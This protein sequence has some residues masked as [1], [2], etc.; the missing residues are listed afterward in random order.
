MKF[1]LAGNNESKLREMNSI[2]TSIG[3][4]VVSQRA[5]GFDIHTEETGSTFEENAF[6][7]ANELMKASNMP[8][9]ADDSGLVV[10]ALDGDP[11][12]YSARYGG[13]SCKSDADRVNLLLKNMENKEQRSAKFVSCVVCIFPDGR[14]IT[15]RGEVMGEIAKQPSGNGGFGYD[16]VFYLPEYEATM[17]EITQEKKNMVSHRGRAL[18]KLRIELENMEYVNN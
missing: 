6:L 7:K 13:E 11:G 8:T 16:P 17:A 5:L 10:D 15:V 9:I 1:V 4:E 14:S 3:I 18:Q 12:V 2:L